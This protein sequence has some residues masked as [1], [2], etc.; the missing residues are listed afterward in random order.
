MSAFDHMFYVR[1][2][3]F[4]VPL[5]EAAAKAQDSNASQY[6]REALAQCLLEDGFS[7][8]AEQEYALTCNGALVLPDIP[9]DLKHLCGTTILTYWPTPVVGDGYEWLPITEDGEPNGTRPKYRV[10]GERV[11]RHYGEAA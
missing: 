5:I 9:A 6:A 11:I 10:D 3:K 1:I 2:P 7:T 8:T 4:W